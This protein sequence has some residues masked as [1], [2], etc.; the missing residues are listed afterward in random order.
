[1]AT[2]HG[3]YQSE[4]L[5]GTDSNDQIYG[6]NGDD[7][8]YGGAGNDRLR[9]GQGNDWHDGGSG[10][11]DMLG[12]TGNDTYCVDSGWDF[13]TEYSGHGT[14][15]VRSAI[16]YGLPANVERLFLTGSA[17]NGG[18]N[19][20]DNIVYGTSGINY[21]WG[22]GGD[23]SLRG[24]DGDDTLY[25][26]DGEDF[27]RGD[28]G[29]DTLWGNGDNDQLL[30][31]DDDDTLYGG[32]LHDILDGGSDDDTLSGGNGNDTLV[33]GSGTDRLDGGAGDD[34]LDF[35]PADLAGAGTVINGGAGAGDVLS[36]NGNVL[37]LIAL[38]DDRIVGVEVL[39]LGNGD[40]TVFASLS[41]IAAL[42]DSDQLVVKGQAG[43]SFFSTGQGWTHNGTVT[44]IGVDYEHYVFGGVDLY[45]ASLIAQWVS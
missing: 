34:W 36:V 4:T 22:Y 41:D 40:N 9:G 21:L 30:G 26:N 33:G 28:A 13:V 11:D 7:T 24:F 10:G 44:V 45:V 31:G 29:N 25:G 18:G 42:S 15:T 39:H 27:L 16:N 38:A 43:D 20:L 19:D 1:M 5:D 8:L 32:E 35:D 2:I 23:D 3:T 37:D 6:M 14:D 17:I 12:G